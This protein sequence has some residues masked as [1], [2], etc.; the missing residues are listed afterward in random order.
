MTAPDAD[1]WPIKWPELISPQGNRWANVW[2]PSGSYEFALHVSGHVKIGSV[3]R[4]SG[5]C[6]SLHS[7]S[8]KCP[9][10]DLFALRA[11]LL[12]EVAEHERRARR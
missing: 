5:P 10:P 11:Y 12:E 7:Y 9:L 2:T 8:H 4:W 6:E 3:V 1:W